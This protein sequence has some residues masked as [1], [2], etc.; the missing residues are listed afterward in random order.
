[1]Y[2]QHATFYFIFTPFLSRP[3]YY[4]F[5]LGQRHHIRRRYQNL[6]E[7]FSNGS[8][9]EYARVQRLYRKEKAAGKQEE[10]NYTGKE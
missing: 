2:T 4:F 3:A 7:N 9:Y 5:R 8:T 6:R 10:K 1:M